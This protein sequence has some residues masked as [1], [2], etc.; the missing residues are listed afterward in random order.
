MNTFYS[1]LLKP[2]I[3]KR[4]LLPIYLLIAMNSVV[5]QAIAGEA[6]GAIAYAPSARL[7]GE[8]HDYPS[9]G[10]AESTARNMCKQVWD[11]TLVISFKNSC[12]VL[13]ERND[14]WTTAWSTDLEDAKRNAL[15]KCGNGCKIS[16]SSCSTPDKHTGDVLF[17]KPDGGYPVII[18]R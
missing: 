3:Y 13:V 7:A 9:R 1:K 16:I 4:Q 11:C 18:D 5:L 2:A 17:S 14:K 12:G 10:E 8:A 15:S 6:Y